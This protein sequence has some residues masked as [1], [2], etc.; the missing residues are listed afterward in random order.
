MG[1]NPGEPTGFGDDG[2][3]RLGDGTIV[4]S[5]D[6]EL[7]L[8]TAAHVQGETRARDRPIAHIA[9]DRRPDRVRLR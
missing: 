9:C 2:P 6:G 5:V 3:T 1:V 4:L 7:D 8:D